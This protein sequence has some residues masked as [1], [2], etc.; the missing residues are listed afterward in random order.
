MP[1]KPTATAERSRENGERETDTAV[2]V[3]GSAINTG[4]SRR[5]GSN[6]Q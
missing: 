1:S 6:P 4:G 5:Q 3:A 2:A